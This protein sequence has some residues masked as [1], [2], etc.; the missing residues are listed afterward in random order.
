MIS[1]IDDTMYQIMRHATEYTLPERSHTTLNQRPASSPGQVAQAG[2]RN[3]TVKIIQCPPPVES[4]CQEGS[5]KVR[6]NRALLS[7]CVASIG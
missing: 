6:G 1:E 7:V 3:R 2:G 4:T 5:P